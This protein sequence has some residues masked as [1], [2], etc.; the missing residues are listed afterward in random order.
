MKAAL[1]IGFALCLSPFAVACSADGNPI[2]VSVNGNDLGAAVPERYLG[3]SFEPTDVINDPGTGPAKP[4][5][6]CIDNCLYHFMVLLRPGHIRIGGLLGESERNRSAADPTHADRLLEFARSIGWSIDWQ[7]RLSPYDP[8]SS[9]VSVG[10]LFEH[11]EDLLRFVSIGNEPECYVF[12]ARR[13][14]DWGVEEYCSEYG[15]YVRVLRGAF[16]EIRLFGPDISGDT[17]YFAPYCSWIETFLERHAESLAGASL[18]LYPSIGSAQSGNMV[19]ELQ[20]LLSRKTRSDVEQAISDVLAVAGEHGLDLWI[21][22]MNAGSGETKGSFNKVASALNTLDVLLLAAEM[23]VQSAAIHV[24]GRTWWDRSPVQMGDWLRS[25]AWCWIK[26]LAYAMLLFSEADPKQFV[27]C[28]IEAGEA[29]VFAYAFTRS[30][31]RLGVV[32]INKDVEVAYDVEVKPGGDQSSVARAIALEGVWHSTKATLGGAKID[33]SGE[34][35]PDWRRIPVS[36]A[37]L[38]YPLAPATAA[39]IVF[40]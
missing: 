30:D 8:Q 12:Q 4:D 16:P 13:P 25:T 24:G 33:P 1:V 6:F 39:L 3:L 29:N 38:S 35:I 26:P 37:S 31:G 32:L 17:E 21:S 18:H 19:E 20:A 40:E 34:W 36:V 7:A 10:Y 14:P 9:I 2:V 15:A 28:D 11:G 23:G 27:G 22:E 5:V